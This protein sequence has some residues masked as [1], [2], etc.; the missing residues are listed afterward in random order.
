[1]LDMSHYYDVDVYRHEE[2]NEV[3]WHAEAGLEHDL[4]MGVEH[5]STQD[6]NVL[7]AEVRDDTIE[8]RRRWPNLRVRFFED[9]R[10]PAT[11]FFAAVKAAGTALPEWVHL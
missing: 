9:R 5:E 4:S 1:M 8:F 7:L 11:E 10:Q 2:A 6:V 3:W